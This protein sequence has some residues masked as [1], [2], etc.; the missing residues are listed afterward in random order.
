[1]MLRRYHDRPA[2]DE[3]PDGPPPPS[4][5]DNGNG[6]DNIERPARS[7]SKVD[8]VAY[9]VALGA[10]QADAEQLT[11]DQLAEQYGSEG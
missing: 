8:W 9:A 3:Q 4:G 1:M 6:P 2:A 10:E 5:D 11:R 7:A